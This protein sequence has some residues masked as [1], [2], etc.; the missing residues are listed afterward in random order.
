M[1]TFLQHHANNLFDF[2]SESAEGDMKDALE[3]DIPIAC[4]V[5]VFDQSSWQIRGDI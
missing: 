1:D 2:G 3:G 4:E 5:H